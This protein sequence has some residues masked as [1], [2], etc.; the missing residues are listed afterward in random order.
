MIRPA[1]VI[2]FCFVAISSMSAQQIVGVLLTEN[3]ADGGM[4]GGYVNFSFSDQK[5]CEATLR[6]YFR[7][8][9]VDC[10]QCKVQGQSCSD[11]LPA[12]LE[13]MRQNSSFSV[14][15]VTQGSTRHWFMG[16]S[17]AELVN[18]CR[19]TAKKMVQVGFSD[20]RC[21]E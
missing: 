5:I 13:P 14:P 1:F 15:Y 16:K 18:L 20:A 6:N 3:S 21:I 2:A 8:L 12:R 9:L 17:R 19:N 10:P 11:R 7:G 4:T